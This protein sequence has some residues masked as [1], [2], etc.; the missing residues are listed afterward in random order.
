MSQDFNINYFHPVNKTEGDATLCFIDGGNM[1][2]VD[3]H[4]F[5]VQLVRVYFNLFKG[6]N[7]I[8]P[9]K[10]PP[11]IEFYAACYAVE[12][13][14]KIFYETELVPVKEE[15]SRF[16]P[17]NN[18]LNIY[19]FDKTLS[20]GLWRVPAYFHSAKRRAAPATL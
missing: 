11:R 16:L 19:S 9:K 6:G 8:E 1:P 15:W 13:N 5:S 2:I 12:N 10:L 18:D 20:I 17:N 3:A 4:N 7:R 14:G